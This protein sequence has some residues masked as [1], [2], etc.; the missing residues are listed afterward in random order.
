LYQRIEPVLSE[1]FR[2]IVELCTSNS[3]LEVLVCPPMY[4]RS[5]IW[6][7]DSLPEILNLFSTPYAE[8]SLLVKNIHELSSFATPSFTSD[9]VHLT[10]YSGM[11]FMLHLFDSAK[12]TLYSLKVEPEARSSHQSEVV[13][14]LGNRVIAVEQD[15]RCLSDAFDLKSAI[16]AEL[17]CFRTNERNEDSFII[18]GLNPIR[19]GLSGHGWQEEAKKEVTRVLKMFYP[20]DVRIVVVHNVSGRSPSSEVTLSVWLASVEDARSICAKFGSYFAGG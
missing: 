14:A 20:K 12:V 2:I 19:D 6:Y 17:A 3:S 18:S 13:R 4:R 15:H 16:N 9:G 1:F 11:E 7:R 5:P 10:S 8:R